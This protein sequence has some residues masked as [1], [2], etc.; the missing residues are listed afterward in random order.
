VLDNVR[1]LLENAYVAVLLGL[2]LAFALLLASRAS[3]KRIKPEA[4]TAGVAIA[5]ISLFARLALATAALWAYK[6]FLTPGFKPFAFSLA[7]GFIVLYTVSIVRYSNTL[8]RRPRGVR[9]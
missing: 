3:F 5:A 4:A 8:K 7:G 1:P 6:A 2:L 9:D